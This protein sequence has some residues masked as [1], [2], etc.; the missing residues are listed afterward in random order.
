[1]ATKEGGIEIS[2]PERKKIFRGLMP[3]R[4]KIINEVVNI[5]KTNVNGQQIGKNCRS[6]ADQKNY[7]IDIDMV[8]MHPDSWRGPIDIAK[9]NQL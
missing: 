5:S 3:Q 8:K 2:I 6:R 9:K 7:A 4:Q 1:M